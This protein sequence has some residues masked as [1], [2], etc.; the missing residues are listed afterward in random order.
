MPGLT[1]I[2]LGKE[3]LHI[4]KNIKIVLISAF[5]MMEDTS[6][7]FV[8][9]PVPASRTLGNGTHETELKD[10]RFIEVLHLSFGPVN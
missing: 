10:I 1:G 9:K 4:D 3:L 7:E 2:E 5:E 8:K 6:F